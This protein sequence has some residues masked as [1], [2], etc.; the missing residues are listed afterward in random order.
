MGKALSSE[1]FDKMDRRKIGRLINVL[2]S[3]FFGTAILIFFGCSAVV[4]KL[5]VP[6]INYLTVCLSFS[7]AVTTSIMIFGHISGAHINP[8]ISLTAV[9]YGEMS[10]AMFILYSVFQCFGAAFGYYL[11]TILYPHNSRIF[12]PKTQT[13]ALMVC[14]NVM[15]PFVNGSMFRVAMI[16]A[17]TTG[18]LSL[19]ICSI[20]DHRNNSR[21]STAAIGVGIVALA[22]SVPTAFYTSCSMNPARSFGP[23]FVTGF[24]TDQWIFWIGPF[25]GSAVASSLYVTVFKPS[26]TIPPRT[27]NP[28]IINTVKL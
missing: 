12:S 24:W 10:L 18:I 6:E 23:A 21:L 26:Y 27:R 5:I 7:A 11:I 13:E 28:I 22:M 25:V 3:E 19:T 17:I 2:L 1:D 9:I 8:A 4:G 16:E 20:W 15:P 14:C